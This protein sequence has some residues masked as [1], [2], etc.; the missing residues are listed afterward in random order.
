MS[1]GYLEY[2]KRWRDSYRNRIILG[3]HGNGVRAVDGFQ[4]TISHDGVRA[5]D[6]LVDARH[7]RK[8]GRV[9]DDG[10]LDSGTCKVLS[11]LVALGG[12]DR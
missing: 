10:R 1:P 5:N 4:A 6:D 3:R 8:H 11:Q 9:G 2:H 7:H 12:E